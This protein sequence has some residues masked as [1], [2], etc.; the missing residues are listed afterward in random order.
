MRFK[1]IEWIGDR[2]KI[3]DQRMLP[4]QTVY[5]IVRTP[6]E[7]SVA[8]RTL[9]VRGAPLI[10]VATAYGLV[11]GMISSKAN[12]KEEFLEDFN[13]VACAL[14]D[15]RPT[16][17]NLRWAVERMKKVVNEINCRRESFNLNQ[18]KQRL[19][20]EALKIHEEDKKIC[21]RIGELG[22]S[23]IKNGFKIMTHCNAGALGTTGDGTATAMIYNALKEGK[24]IKVFVGE[25]RPLFQGARLTCWEMLQNGVDITLITDSMVGWFLKKEKI[26]CVL[27]GADR[28]SRNG[29]IANK[30]GTYSLA[31]LAREHE[32]PF[33]V[34]SPVSSFD[35]AI[36]NGEQIPI[37]ERGREEIELIGRNRISPDNVSIRNPAF[38]IT[39]SKYVSAIV[40]ERGIIW[41]PNE[42][43]I[44]KLC[45]KEV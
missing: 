1:T 6:L 12:T 33:Y 30:I 27:V 16:A 26:N 5:R 31:I 24:K 23:L 43:K 18:V 37:E 25:T 14:I 4:N 35:L 44:V 20:E 21:D 10:G 2:V 45:L 28:I 29:D 9:R 40:T 3:L 34:A 39:P 11:L 7:M 17:V 8:I 38:D 13:K 22:S 19:L 41:K 36:E 42:R 32:I 15:T